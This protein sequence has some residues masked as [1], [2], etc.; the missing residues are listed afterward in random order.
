MYYRRRHHWGEEYK[1]TAGPL[2]TQSVI[3]GLNQLA[4]YEVWMTAFTFK[5]GPKSES[6]S[7]VIGECI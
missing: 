1:V 5:E 7:I 4:E 3:S 6:H 2:D